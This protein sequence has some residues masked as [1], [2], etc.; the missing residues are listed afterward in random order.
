MI[1]TII[2]TNALLYV[3]T[4]VGAL[5]ILCQFLLSGR[6]RMLIREASDTQMEKKDF[7][8]QLRYKFRMNRKRSNEHTD[9]HIFV[10]RSLMDYKFWRLHLHQW[11]RL[12]A[13]CFLASMMAAAAGLIYCFRAEGM[14]VYIENILWTTGGVA[15][16]TGLA[17]MW[18]DYPYKEMYLRTE[19]EDYLCCFAASGEAQ[20][21]EEAAP[22]KERMRAPSI[23]GIRKKAAL[24][25][26]TKAQKDKRELKN[27]LAKLKEGSREIAAGNEQQRERNRE[28]LRQMDAQEQERIIRDVLA[29]FLA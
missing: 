19:L 9:I 11:K 17:W 27:N 29:E 7:M 4:A 12:A 14:P 2:E 15:L 1:R 24:P 3:M 25:L 23:I 21:A 28:V 6:Y 8:K 18:N 5:G 16:T 13:G 20:E 10:K 26:E 22:V